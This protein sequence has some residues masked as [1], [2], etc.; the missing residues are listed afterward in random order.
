MLFFFKKKQKKHTK[1]DEE[2]TQKESPAEVMSVK[3][4]LKFSSPVK[5][6]KVKKTLVILYSALP[7]SKT[8]KIVR[9]SNISSVFKFFITPAG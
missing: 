5:F 6:R 7:R 9:A 3:N 4:C 2:K 8:T 1:I